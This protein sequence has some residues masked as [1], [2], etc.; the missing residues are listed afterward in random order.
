MRYILTNLLLFLFIVFGNAQINFKYLTTENGLSDNGI[1]ALYRDHK[2]YIWIGTNYKGLNKYDGSKVTIYENIDNQPGSISNNDI[3]YIYEDSKNN[4]WIGTLDGLNLYNPKTESFTVFNHDT[5]DTIGNISNL[6]TCII[7]DKKGNLWVTYSDGAGLTKWNYEK[8]SYKR[9][10]IKTPDNFLVN[11]MTSIREDSRGCLWVA[12]KGAGVYQFNPETGVFINYND[13][14][15]DFGN[16][17]EKKLCVDKNDQIWIG[18]FGNGLFSFDPSSGRFRHFGT[19]IGNKGI[20]NGLIRDLI[21]TDENHLLIATDQGGINCYD[22][23]S[24]T[25]EY[26]GQD[27]KNELN[28]NGILCLHQDK[29]NILWVGTSRGGVNYFNPMGHKFKLHNN[30]KNSNSLSYNIVGCFYEDS[31]G[32]IWIGTDGGG[33]NIYNPQTENFTIYKHDSSNPNSISGNVIRSI[34]EDKNG[35]MWIST[36]DAGLNR[37]DKKTKRF[38]HYLPNSQD[39]SS[40]SNKTIWHLKIDHNN[41]IWLGGYKNGVEL[42]NKEAGVFRRFS[43]NRE[44]P[45]SL[46]YDVVTLIYEDFQN[47]I[48]I[49]TRNGINLYNDLTNSFTVYNKFPDNNILAFCRDKEGRLWAGSSAKGLFLFEQDG[50]IK[51]IYSKKDGLP[52]NTIHAI[53]E[54]NNG[55][56]W[57]STN[58]GVSCFNQKKHEFKNYSKSD[59]LQG[60]VFFEQSFLKTRSGE[61]YFGGYNGFNSFHPDSI[62]DNDYISEVYITDFKLF[63]KSV[64]FGIPESPLQNHISETKE[65]TLSWQQSV[66]SFEFIAINYTNSEKNLYAYKMDGFD[67]DW[68]YTDANKRHATYTNLNAGEYTFHVKASNKN[69]IWNNT[70]TTIKIII[71][72]PWWKTWWFKILLICLIL[73]SI[74][75]IFN[76]RTYQLR[77]QKLLLS[78]KVKERTFQLEE[79]NKGLEEKQK[80]IFI[81]NKELQLQKENL[82]EINMTLEIQAQEIECQNIELNQH[83]NH[84]EQLVKERTADLEEA[85]KKAEESNRLKSAFLSN[86][87]HEIRTPMNAIVGFSSMLNDLDLPKDE[88]E[89]LVSVVKKNSEELLGLIEDILEMSQIQANQLVIN[90]QPVNIIE[91]MNE[92]FASYQQKAKSKGIQ[93]CVDIDA[94]SDTLLCSID[95]IRLK[96]VLA[97]LISNAIKFTEIGY[98]QFGIISHPENYIAF[99]VKDSGI[100][101]PDD[102]GCDIFKSFQK[103]EST[104]SKIYGG[105]GLGLSIS[106]NLIRRMG[107]TIW[108][109]SKIGKGTNFYFTIP[110]N[111]NENIEISEINDI[112]EHLIS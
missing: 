18:S 52:G 11:S 62:L 32:L 4:L 109:E 55:N 40:I 101:I 83:R 22:M 36:W 89:E 51:E 64:P 97:N 21:Q 86:I 5:T 46:G 105:V 57:M 63:N 71:L 25:F 30:A 78:D 29:E 73:F 79:I 53:V 15:L 68:I 58:N 33:V 50:I 103:V 49:C 95:G 14:T 77:K 7:E 54:D 10:L 85:M 3:R 69:G 34:D 76:Y 59:G 92:L 17:L 31:E 75:V 41:D 82:K 88:R 16:G 39:S 102:I 93:L 48:W 90:N 61:I 43:A 96:Q 104:K 24:K 26:I 100:G 9:Y 6:V 87:S 112:D 70:E 94:F 20:N 45:R 2:D 107:G 74:I 60:N 28:N 106:Y 19:D 13:S 91:I 108:Y 37:Y 67:K 72:P 81:K 35:D 12:S 44:D 98:V 84:L 56:L 27:K 65:I 42:F 110:N 111:N 66:F 38:Y 99:Y 80:E 1:F 47:N 8:N 23:V